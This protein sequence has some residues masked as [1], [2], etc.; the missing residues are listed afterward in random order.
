MPA[1]ETKKLVLDRVYTVVIGA[2]DLHES[3]MQRMEALI[4]RA[5]VVHMVSQLSTMVQYPHSV[6]ENVYAQ[7]AADLT[8][9]GVA[10]CWAGRQNSSKV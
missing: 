4:M 3:V 8:A 1:K 9:M 6:G 5:H 10:M 2:I 7:A